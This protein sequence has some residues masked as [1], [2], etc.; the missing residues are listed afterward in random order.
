MP[1]LPQIHWPRQRWKKI[2]RLSKYRMAQMKLGP[3]WDTTLGIV[4]LFGLVCVLLSSMRIFLYPFFNI[5]GWFN[6]KPAWRVFLCRKIF[7][8]EPEPG[9]LR[10]ITKEAWCGL[11][12]FLL[13]VAIGGFA[14]GDLSPL[15]WK[16]FSEVNHWGGLLYGVVAVVLVVIADVWLF[17]WA[18]QYALWCEKDK[19]DQNPEVLVAKQKYYL[20]IN[21]V[22][23]LLLVSKG[24]AAYRLLIAI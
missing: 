22:V 18:S 7:I 17:F 4:L 24:N 10:F 20:L 12:L 3:Y 23:G 9:F 8:D 11:V 5:E 15:P 16:A 6:T 2:W 13:P 1:K 21:V 19:P 14:R